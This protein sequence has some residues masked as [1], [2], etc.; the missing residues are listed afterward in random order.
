[1][2]T[3]LFSPCFTGCGWAVCGRDSPRSQIFACFFGTI[4]ID[5]IHV[6][7]KNGCIPL[8]QFRFVLCITVVLYIQSVYIL[9]IC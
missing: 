3:L 9:Y 4:H 6:L 8:K 1:M 5:K 2:S 7:G